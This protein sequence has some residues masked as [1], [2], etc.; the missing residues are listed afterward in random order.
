MG[1]CLVV[2]V[3]EVSQPSCYESG[4]KPACDPQTLSRPS[5]TFQLPG[6]PGDPGDPL[7]LLGIRGLRVEQE[8]QTLHLGKVGT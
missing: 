6:E 4:I 3:D 5:M 2:A 8:E 1:I 7:I